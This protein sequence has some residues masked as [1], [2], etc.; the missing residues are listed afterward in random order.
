MNYIWIMLFLL[1]KVITDAGFFF[2]YHKSLSDLLM[3]MAEQVDELTEK[4]NVLEAAVKELK[5]KSKE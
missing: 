1:V 5:R 3:E 2:Y 4:V